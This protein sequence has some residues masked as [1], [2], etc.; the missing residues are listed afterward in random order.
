M[1]TVEE[2]E[3][4]NCCVSFAFKYI[5]CTNVLVRVNWRLCQSFHRHIIF[6]G[7]QT[8]LNLDKYFG[9]CRK[10]KRSA[11]A[12]MAIFWAYGFESPSS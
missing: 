12:A 11:V 8:N 4:A 10:I 2:N 3:D 1:G 5:T 6:V 9:L 7:S